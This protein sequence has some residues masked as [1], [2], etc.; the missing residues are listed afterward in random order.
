G[1]EAFSYAAIKHPVVEI[2]VALR[3]AVGA[4]CAAEPA[5]EIADEGPEQAGNR[6][7]VHGRFPSLHAGRRQLGSRPAQQQLVQVLALPLLHAPGSPLPKVWFIG[8]DR[9]RRRWFV[10]VMF[11]PSPVGCAFL[12]AGSEGCRR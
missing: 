9:Y 5:A 1:R 11:L 7:R 12:S 6:F 3:G 4:A 2:V 8:I 10:L